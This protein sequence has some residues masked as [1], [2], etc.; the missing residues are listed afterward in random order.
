MAQIKDRTKHLEPINLLVYM[1]NTG[2]KRPKSAV[3][4]TGLPNLLC[5]SHNK[6][7]N[8]WA[9]LI[10]VSRAADLWLSAR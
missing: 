8:S 10:L 5:M 1:L 6:H 3:F 7:L 4:F 9:D 2:A